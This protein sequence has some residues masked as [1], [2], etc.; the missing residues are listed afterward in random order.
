MTGVRVERG[1]PGVSH[2]V[3]ERPER[4]NALGRESIEALRSGLAALGED[5]E[6]RVVLL[7]AEGPDFC[8]GADL[9]EV[10]ASME[11]GP[12]EGLRDAERIGSLFL[13]MR[14]HPE[15]IVAAVH[16]RA[17]AGGFGLAAACD[18]VLAEDG[19]A[20]GLPEIRL[21]FVPAMVLSLLRRRIPEGAL[22]ALSALGNPIDAAEARRLGFVHRVVEPGRLRPAAEE[23]AVALAA[24]P[25][26]ALGMTKRL[27]YGTDGLPLHEGIARGAE[28]NALAR[29]TDECREGIR[30]FL[31]GG[32][33][34]AGG[35]PPES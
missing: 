10:A 30:G 34:G 22:F 26:G 1:A 8:A 14:A 5:T 9:R 23:L 20:F 13:A 7:R 3:L 32:N 15:P 24:R 31:E 29:L 33:A 17:L 16:G 28:V 6:S 19:A 18:L 27:L 4:R 2:L 12:E 35:P 25:A 21:G 11:N